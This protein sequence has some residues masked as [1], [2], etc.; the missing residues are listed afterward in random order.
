VSGVIALLRS[1]FPDASV[2]ALE[3]ALKRSALDVDLPGPDNAGG[4]GLVDAQRAFAALNALPAI[5]GTYT[6]GAWYL[7]TNGNGL[8]ESGVDTKRQFGMANDIPVTGD[9]NGDGTIDIGVF[10]NI[11]DV[12]YWYLDSNGSGSWD[13]GSDQ[14]LQFGKG[15]DIPVAGDWNGDGITEVGVFRNAD[16]FGWWY[17]DSNGNAAWDAG[18]DQKLQFGIGT[19]VPVPGDWNGDGVTDLGV[20]RNI[21]GVG[22]WYLD[23]NGNRAWDHGVDQKLQ[24]GLASDLPVTGDWNNDGN[25]D[26]GI[27]RAGRW[28]LDAN[29]NGRW[30]AGDH[31]FNFGTA[32]MSPVTSR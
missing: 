32:V 30:D 21:N 18:I 19:D 1:V 24:F 28:Y 22:Y 9:W 4:Y 7:D 27:Y 15:N 29:G 20:Y 6:A 17:L 16:G 10:R 2:L 13:A 26:L 23:S 11:N 14:K 3:N 31:I 5:I 12:G 8:W 25:L